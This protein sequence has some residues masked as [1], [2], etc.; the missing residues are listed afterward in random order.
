[1]D[2]KT[3]FL[4]DN[5]LIASQSLDEIE[6]LKTRLKSEFEMKELGKAKVI[7]GMEITKRVSTLLASQFKISAAMSPKNDAERA[8]MEKVPY[9]N[10]VGIRI[11]L[12]KDIGKLVKWILRYIHNTIDVGLV[13]ENGSSQWVEGYCDSDYAGDLDKR[14]STTG[15]VFTLAKAPVSWKF[16][17]QSTTALST[18]EAKYM[19]M[20]EAVKEAIWLQGLLGELGI[21]QKFVTMHSDS[22][23][24]IHLAK[25]QVYHARTEHIDVRYHFIREILEEVEDW[26][27]APPMMVDDGIEELIFRQ[28][29]DLLNNGSYWNTNAFNES[30]ASGLQ[31]I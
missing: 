5:M 26:F 8:Y 18:T 14:R 2:V 10:V 9:A 17:L 6:T 21:K 13:F 4:H 25:N 3:A 22:Q 20:T 15:Y 16:T 12:E 27:E 31:V 24:A 19:V 11:T 30:Q 28:G 1:M 29:G 23:S 7:L